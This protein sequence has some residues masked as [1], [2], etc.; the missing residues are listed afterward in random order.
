MPGYLLDDDV[1]RVY[2]EIRHRPF[3]DLQTLKSRR[4]KRNGT[5]LAENGNRVTGGFGGRYHHA[6]R[7]PELH[8]EP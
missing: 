7:R 3:R 1:L 6:N 5:I 4:K 2:I 8:T